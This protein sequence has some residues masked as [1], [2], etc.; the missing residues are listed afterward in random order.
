MTYINMK[1][2]DG[3]E[4]I[5]EFESRKEARENLKEY[6]LAFG[7]TPGKLYLS[8]RCTREWAD[9]GGPDN[10]GLSIGVLDGTIGT[11]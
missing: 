10:S 4:T 7:P 5:D 3:V 9:R 11:K 2:S 8:S 1:G 6:M